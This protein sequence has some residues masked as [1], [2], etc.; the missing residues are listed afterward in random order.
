VKNL[1]G[2]PNSAIKGSTGRVYVTNDN[3]QVILDITK[4]RVKSV[5]PGQEFGPKRAP[6]PE[7]LDLIS[8]LHGD[9]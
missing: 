5:T 7:E 1:T 9:S 4:E 6:T 3:G 8:K 2:P